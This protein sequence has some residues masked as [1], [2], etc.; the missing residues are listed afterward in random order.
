MAMVLLFEYKRTYVV[1]HD[2]LPLITNIS[3]FFG[4]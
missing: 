3:E 1:K 4:N 2:M